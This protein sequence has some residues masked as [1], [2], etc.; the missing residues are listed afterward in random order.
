[1]SD[2]EHDNFLCHLLFDNWEYAFLFGVISL[3]FVVVLSIISIIA[4]AKKFHRNSKLGGFIVYYT[5]K[6][7]NCI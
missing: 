4:L 5:S 6:H 7:N 2:Y 3:I 1:M